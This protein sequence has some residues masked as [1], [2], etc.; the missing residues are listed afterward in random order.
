MVV[1]AISTAIVL[2]ACE[3]PS[4]RQD[5]DKTKETNQVETPLTQPLPDAEVQAILKQFPGAVPYREGSDSLLSKLKAFGIPTSSLLWGQSTC[6][7][8]IISTKNK[9]APGIKG[10]FNF[11]GLAGLPFTGVAGLDA[12]AHHVPEDGAAVLFVGPHIGYNGSEGWGKILRHDQHHPSACCGALAAALAKLRKGELKPMAPGKDDYQE[13][14][15]EQL[16]YTHRDKILASTEP[17]VTL[18]QLTYEDAI[19]TLS[20]YASKVRERHFKYAVVVGAIII[21]TDYMYNDYVWIENVSILDIQ[22]NVW[23][24]GGRPTVA[25]QQLNR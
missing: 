3:R 20:D 14:T 7:D 6:M 4:P 8:D 15:L 1:L 11:G 23:V 16:A 25:K 10:P 13:Q 18:T 12:F 2:S 5:D 22:K 21:N 19:K 9:L 17:L 24:L